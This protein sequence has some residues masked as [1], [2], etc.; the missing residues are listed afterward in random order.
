MNNKNIPTTI[1]VVI[2]IITLVIFGVLVSVYEKNTPIE[3]NTQKSLD[4]KNNTLEQSVPIKISSNW[5][6]VSRGNFWNN[7]KIFAN[8]NYKFPNIIFSYPDNWELECCND[9]DNS[10]QHIIYSS[11]NHSKQLPYIRIIHYVLT[12]CPALKNSCSLEEAVTM[13]AREKFNSLTSAIQASDI[14]AEIKLNKLH[15]TAFAYK[16]TE[17]NNKFSKGYIINLGK[18]VIEIDF[19]NYELLDNSFFVD[20]LDH[21]SFETN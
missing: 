16:R 17:E 13:T 12:G 2:I 20:F 5:I 18:S 1:G 19:V 10:S 9:M 3:T 15:T 8:T 11:K 21:I 6:P 14:L 4:Q 7:P